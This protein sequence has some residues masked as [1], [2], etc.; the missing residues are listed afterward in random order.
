MHTDERKSALILPSLTVFMCITLIAASER[1]G[2]PDSI[3]RGVESAE[4][5]LNVV[6]LNMHEDFIEIARE[7]W[8]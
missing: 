2:I 1:K 8:L 5:L 3:L 7:Q 4:L 6:K